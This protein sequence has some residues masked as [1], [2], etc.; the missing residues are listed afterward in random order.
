MSA[1]GPEDGQARLLTMGGDLAK[2]AGRGE[3]AA[4]LA[5]DMRRIVWATPA[6]YVLFGHP[7]GTGGSKPLDGRLPVERFLDLARGSA[8]AEGYHLERIR[9]P[10]RR[11]EPVTLAF[12]R[13]RLADGTDGLAVLSPEPTG[14][15][16]RLPAWVFAPEDAEAETAS[17]LPPEPAEEP[18]PPVLRPASG[19]PEDEPVEPA[20]Q[21]PAPELQQ[22]VPAPSAPDVVPRPERTTTQRSLRFTWRT[23]HE[24]RFQ[25][26]DAPVHDVLS[27]SAAA[28]EGRLLHEVEGEFISDPA[29]AAAAGLGWRETFNGAETLWKAGPVSWR[30]VRLGGTPVYGPGERFEGFRGFGVI[31][32]TRTVSMAGEVGSELAARTVAPEQDEDPETDLAASAAEP[33]VPTVD[34]IVFAEDDVERGHVVTETLQ[35]PEPEPAPAPEPEPAPERVR[36]PAAAP[37][38]PR[39]PA[40]P[41]APRA[42]SSGRGL[43]DGERLAFREIA[44]ALGAAITAPENRASPAPMRRPAA[45]APT[46]RSASPPVQAPPPVSAPAEVRSA[47]S[48]DAPDLLREAL[49]VFERLNLGIMLS[50]GDVPILMNRALLDMLGYPDADL[51]HAEGGMERLF[52]GPAPAADGGDAVRVETRDAREVP[53]HVRLNTVSWGGMPATLMTFRPVEADV[54]RPAPPS[55]ALEEELARREREIADLTDILDIA[56]DG[57]LVLDADGRISAANRTAEALFGYEESE[58]LGQSFLTLLAP[59]GHGAALDYLEGLK[60]NGVASLLNDGREVNGRA[61]KGGT[62]PLFMTLGRIGDDPGRRFCA[63]LRDMTAWKRAEADLLAS[64]QEAERASAQKSDVLATISHELRTPMSAVMGFAEVMIEERFGP[65]GNERYK[66]YLRDIHASGSHVLSLVNDLLDMA[67]IEAG[68]F[69]LDF[70]AVD[71]NALVAS[72]V[73]LLQPQAQRGKV[74]LRSGLAPMLPMIVADDRSLKQIVLNLL[75]NAVKF[76]E[77]GGQVIVSTAFTDNGEVVIRVRDTGVGM[78][79]SEIEAAMEPFRQTRAGRR[80]G[81][82]GLGL[83]LTKALVEANRASLAIRSGRDQGTLVEVTFPTTRVL[84]D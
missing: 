60:S 68:R 70:R 1:R 3:A 56:T 83:P 50:R 5:A 82:T 80:A 47:A 72:S 66:E 73:N 59:D 4:V 46:V 6:G 69:E 2:A 79:P 77:P 14:P 38:V 37:P 21:S 76:T 57:V 30:P 29:G 65:V 74:V 18:V 63:V 8:P 42:E 27:P 48:D 61:R 19:P 17:P 53:M 54:A 11:F 71:A 33:D 45:E 41:A 23:D 25:P 52:R 64:K 32:L 39:E 7:E 16:E 49:D 31:D 58:I 35:E 28:A 26:F 44:R 78:D 12:R 15:V 62:M 51:F 22:S 67:K 9:M 81:G 43:S 10:G 55:G 84:A 36:A 13:V 75:S 24:G 20:P 40:K 34:D